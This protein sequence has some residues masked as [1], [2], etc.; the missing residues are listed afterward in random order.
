MQI[1]REKYIVYPEVLHFSGINSVCP[2]K[3]N[4]ACEGSGGL[5][6]SS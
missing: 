5:L 1:I 3:G 2:E 6:R 4:K